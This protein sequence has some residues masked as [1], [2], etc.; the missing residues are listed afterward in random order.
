MTSA[1]KVKSQLKLKILR[2][3]ILP[4]INFELRLYNF[5]SAWL[6]EMDGIISKYIRHWTEAPISSTTVIQQL[7]RHK[8][9]LNIPSMKTLAEK[10]KISKRHSL[11]NSKNENIVDLFKSTSHQNV[12]S[13]R[14]LN[15]NPSLENAT[16][17]HLSE[18]NDKLIAKLKTLKL[19]SISISAVHA[20]IGRSNILL[21]SNT[22]EKLPGTTFNF[23]RKGLLGILPTN[24]RLHAWGRIQTPNCSLCQGIQTNKHVLSNCGS[25][26]ALQRYKNRHDA[27]LLNL[28][29]WLRQEIPEGSQLY[30]DLPTD[31]FPKV[32]F[33]NSFRPD[34]V[35]RYGNVLSVGELTIC[36]ESNLSKSRDYKTLKY[37]S[38]S[39]DLKEQY[40]NMEVKLSTIEFTTLG[41]LKD[42]STFFK[43]SKVTAN[44]IPT[45]LKDAISRN[46][47]YN[48]FNIYLNRNNSNG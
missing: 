35:I 20:E 1:L 40:Y 13:D 8:A 39:S 9:G 17:C 48:S 25:P 21:W 3:S 45:N 12:N 14:F 38:L 5:S 23:V 6:D 24:A 7:P 42:C 34:I 4:K 44:K 2:Q 43:N 11:L 30:A 36:H 26:M 33:F 41:L 22:I 10:A 27:A 47:I 29:V 19:Q 15:N 16:K 18:T 31:Q 37:D 28:C 46:I 32:T